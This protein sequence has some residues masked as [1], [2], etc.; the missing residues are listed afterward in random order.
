MKKT[1]K[2]D[3]NNQEKS[4][5]P[6]DIFVGN[7]IRI[8]RN[9]LGM[10]QEKLAALLGIAFQQIQKYEKGINRVGA[11]RLWDISNILRTEI[12]YFYDGINQDIEDQSPRRFVLKA[13]KQL[14]LAEER[15]EYFPNPMLNSETRELV[16]SYYKIKNRT[17]AHQILEMLKSLAKSSEAEDF[18]NNETPEE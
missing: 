17:V 12:S 15:A 14:Y 7:R 16:T 4:P 11:S 8:R 2:Q 9:F 10:S 6:I 18:E 3:N 13:P 1:Q 5:N